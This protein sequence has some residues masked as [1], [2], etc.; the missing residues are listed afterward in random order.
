MSCSTAIPIPM[1]LILRSNQLKVASVMFKYRYSAHLDAM[2]QQIAQG[3]S[4]L[5][6]SESNYQRVR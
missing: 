6:A 4:Q 3:R 5:L 2:R 1:G